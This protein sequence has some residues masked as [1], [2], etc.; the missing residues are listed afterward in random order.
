MHKIGI[1]PSARIAVEIL[2]WKKRTEQEQEKNMICWS[3]IDSTLQALC[4]AGASFFSQLDIRVQCSGLNYFHFFD[5]KLFFVV[6]VVVERERKISRKKAFIRIFFYGIHTRKKNFRACPSD[7]W[8]RRCGILS[9]ICIQ[10][11]IYSFFFLNQLCISLQ[12]GQRA[13]HTPPDTRFIYFFAEMLRASMHGSAIRANERSSQYMIGNW[14]Q[15]H[16]PD[17]CSSF[18]F[19][20]RSLLSFL[21]RTY[22]E[23]F[24]SCNNSL[25]LMYLIAY[26]FCSFAHSSS[27]SL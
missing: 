15:I 9:R 26:F 14:Y 25:A 7:V 22:R 12:K 3:I 11:Y 27:V 19:I 2:Q 10:L 8:S 13:T 17:P 21:L 5:N 16:Y 4:C 20:S 23:S 24:P 18:F 6:V 1:Y